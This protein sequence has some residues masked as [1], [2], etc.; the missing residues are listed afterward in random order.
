MIDVG[1][2][3]DGDV[4]ELSG[5]EGGK[6]NCL[7]GMVCEKVK[8]VTGGGVGTAAGAG[9]GAATGG[10]AA[11]SSISSSLSP[12]IS[13]SISSGWAEVASTSGDSSAA[14]LRPLGNGLTVA[15]RDRGRDEGSGLGGRGRGG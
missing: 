6:L 2:T 13:S 1:M 15:R 4:A 8:V 12:S 3:V 10:G 7:D 5:L 9:C 14:F 11:I